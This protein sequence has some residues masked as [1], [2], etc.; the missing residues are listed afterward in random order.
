MNFVA[1][2]E[3][4]ELGQFQSWTLFFFSFFFFPVILRVFLAIKQEFVFF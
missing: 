4:L 1:L 2:L 3:T